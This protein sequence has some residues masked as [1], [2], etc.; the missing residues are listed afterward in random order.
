VL[1][2]GR[3]ACAATWMGAGTHAYRELLERVK[4]LVRDALAEREEPAGVEPGLAAEAILAVASTLAWRRMAASSPE[5][6]V[7]QLVVLMPGV[8]SPS[9]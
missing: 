5:E 1:L 7:Q 4:V 9:V 3:L 6:A 2:E 8:F